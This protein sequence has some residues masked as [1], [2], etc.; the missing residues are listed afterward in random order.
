V[1]NELILHHVSANYWGN[2]SLLEKNPVALLSSYQC[3]AEKVLATHQQCKIWSET[4][5]TVL[6]GFHSPVEKMCLSHLLRDKGNIII[7]PARGIWKKI[8]ADWEK[9]M[10]EERLLIV[11]IFPPEINR[12]SA[13]RAVARN[14]FICDLAE[15]IYISY[16]VKGGKM[17]KFFREHPEYQEKLRYL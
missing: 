5:Q 7:S 11:S 4:G 16:L 2:L 15:E 14:K 13:D 10:K 8:P 3:A 17:E 9:A 1:S 12:I 6:S